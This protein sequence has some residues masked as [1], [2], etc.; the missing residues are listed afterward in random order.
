[1]ANYE[2]LK[3]AVSD[4]IKTNGNQEITGSVMQSVLLS[5]ISS[6]GKKYQFAGIATPTTNPGTPDQNVFYIAGEGTYVNFSNQIIEVGQLGVL[7][8]NGTWTKEVLEIGAAG[9]NVILE[10]NTD[11][12]T[13]RK[14]VLYK[15]RKTGMVITYK[16]DNEKWV[17]EQYIGTILYDSSWQDNANWNG[18]I[19]SYYSFLVDNVY[20][21]PENTYFNI[22][23]KNVGDIIDINNITSNTPNWVGIWGGL[24]AGCYISCSKYNNNQ[25]FIVIEPKTMKVIYKSKDSSIY[26]KA[27]KYCYVVFST[28]K[29]YVNTK[30]VFTDDNTFIQSIEELYNS[31]LELST[32]TADVKYKINTLNSPIQGN[33]Y[34]VLSDAEIGNIFD[35]KV[36]HF[37]DE[38]K[39][40]WGSVIIPLNEQES[41]KFEKIM[42]YGQGIIAI[43]RYTFE[44]LEI[45]EKSST[46][47]T[48]SYTATQDIYIIST[49]IISDNSYFEISNVAFSIFKSLY[50]SLDYERNKEN[51]VLKD[52]TK[53]LINL[54]AKIDVPNGINVELFAQSIMS[55]DVLDN[56]NPIQY[57]FSTNNNSSKLKTYGE[58]VRLD[59]ITA[60]DVFNIS[61]YSIENINGGD[62]TAT[63]TSNIRLVNRSGGDGSVKNIL[64]SGDSLIEGGLTTP[65]GLM[66]K[67]LSEDADYT[68]NQIG[69]LQK[70]YKDVLYKHE[71]YG[72][73]S[74]ETWTNPI[75]ENTQ[76]AGKT[77]PFMHN[78]VLDFKNYMSVNF[79]ELPQTIDYFIMSLGTNDV[80]QGFLNKTDAQLLEI[81]EKAKT[82]IDAL[83]AD[84]PN[85]KVGIGLPGIGYQKDQI[86][87]AQRFKLLIMKLNSLYIDTFDNGKYNPNV[88]CIMHGAWADPNNSYTM[89][90]QPIGQY[91]PTDER[92]CL[93]RIHPDISG[94]ECWG[95]AYYSKI[96]AWMQGLL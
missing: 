23:S 3:Q 37:G 61:R 60:N 69:L 46:S 81:I 65:V 22:L 88:T 15:N 57:Y 93:D 72:G 68:I 30:E 13:T 9:G 51:F 25:G 67:L 35:F 6:L 34:I 50:L 49:F 33:T 71:G 79:S 5:M 26:Y 16:K 44:I 70:S 58:H 54:T 77:N 82:F 53:E 64:V 19:S 75:Y 89:T 66:Y 29:G 47:Y 84:F 90:E 24:H 28:I 36:N 87:V 73:W 83:L 42:C 92:I 86:F 40:G 52:T 80:G 1:M 27:E 45:I 85:C 10:W 76:S 91:I 8:W 11:V 48:S 96:R 2:Q 41:I 43:D 12:A 95:L 94:Y 21:L 59:G 17:T 20:T 55:K 18:N 39:G 4:V 62:P 14:Q 78:G 7:K 74:W 38:K 31:I 56:Q 63:A 32:L